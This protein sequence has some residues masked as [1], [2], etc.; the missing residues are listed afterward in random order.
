MRPIGDVDARLGALCTSGRAMAEIDAPGA[1]L[2]LLGGNGNIGRP[3]VPAELVHRLRVARAGSAERHRGQSGLVRRIG[4][5]AGKARHAHHAVVLGEVRLERPVVDGPVVRH[6]VQ[7]PHP[8][9]ARVHAREM[10][11]VDNRAASDAIE[12][13]DLHW[14]IVVVDGIIRVSP[15]P[16]GTDVEIA[17][18]ARL[19]I[20][21]VAR[22]IPRFD[23]VAL[24]EAKDL[25]ARVG[26]APGHRRARGARADDEDID[27]LVGGASRIGIRGEGHLRLPCHRRP[28]TSAAGREPRPAAT[29]RL[30]PE[31]D[32]SGTGGRGSRPNAARTRSSR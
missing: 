1:A 8:E 17:E 6:A 13:G 21:T 31:H 28:A 20:A 18:A 4:R 12:V 24:L 7:R 3:P 14:R 22:K 32:L 9:I 23:P 15:S 27:D 10:R 5:I 11:R 26:E 30:A 25:H 19:P 2:V 16:V 29:S